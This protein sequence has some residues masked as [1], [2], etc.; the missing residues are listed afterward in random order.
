MSR[1]GDSGLFLHLGSRLRL[2][3]VN[4]ID[5]KSHWNPMGELSIH[6]RRLTM[7]CCSA[8]TCSWTGFET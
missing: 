1:R 4:L 8:K 6:P 5:A 2:D 3:G 7:V